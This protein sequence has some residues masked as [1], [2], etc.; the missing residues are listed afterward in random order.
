MNSYLWYLKKIQKNLYQDNQLSIGLIDNEI[1]YLDNFILLL[2]Y[3]MKIIFLCILAAWYVGH[4]DTQDLQYTQDY[5]EY[6]EACVY[7]MNTQD[8][9]R[10]ENIGCDE[11]QTIQYMRSIVPYPNY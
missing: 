10:F 11:E 4:L 7:E 1:L 9:E 2:T 3:P 5:P 6:I 8:T